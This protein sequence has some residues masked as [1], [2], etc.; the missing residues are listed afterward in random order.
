M[1]FFSDEHLVK[2]KQ[3]F[4]STASSSSSPIR[5]NM[6]VQQINLKTH[7]KLYLKKMQHI[8]ERQKAHLI[9]VKGEKD[10]RQVKT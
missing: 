9:G 4:V 7:I 8:L 6:K 10:Q 3:E 5:P 2:V 1:C